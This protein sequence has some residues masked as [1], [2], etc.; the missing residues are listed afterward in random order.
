MMKKIFSF[1]LLFTVVALFFTS[2]DKSSPGAACKS[3]MEMMKNG[4]YKGFVQGI[5]TEEGKTA[6]ENEQTAALLEGVLKDKMEK[7]IQEKGGIKDIQIVEENI[8]EDGN[9]A[10]VKMKIVYGDG[11]EK[12]DTQEMVKQNGVWK[13]KIKK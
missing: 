13:M 9:T 2:C 12:E 7:T 6:E 5:A 8:A 1:L 4:D 11:T 3:Y 10:D